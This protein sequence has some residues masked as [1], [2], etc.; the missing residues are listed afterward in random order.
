MPQ[1]FD[2]IERN[3]KQGMEIMHLSMILGRIVSITMCGYIQD[4]SS[5]KKLPL[6]SVVAWLS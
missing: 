6:H 3:S 5:K 1:G 4:I 2:V